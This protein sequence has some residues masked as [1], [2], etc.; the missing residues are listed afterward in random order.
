MTNDV[1]RELASKPIPRLPEPAERIRLREA[2][3]ITQQ[4]LADAIGISRRSVHAYEHGKSEPTG[5]NRVKYAEILAHWAKTE[6]ES[7]ETQ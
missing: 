5:E 2:F 6:R 3:G 4:T 1:L 7:K